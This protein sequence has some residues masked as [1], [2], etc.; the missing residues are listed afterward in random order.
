M[1]GEQELLRAMEE[2]AKE[3]GAIIKGAKEEHVAATEKTNFRDLVTSYDVK[4]QKYAVVFLGG[5]LIFGLQRSCQCMFLS[6]N[7]PKIS[8]FIALLRKVFLLVPLALILPKIF[9]VTGIYLA[10]SV[11]DATAATCCFLIFLR[12]FPKILDGVRKNT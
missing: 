1:Y 2:I 5:F 7:Q 9:G 8:L 11:A 4:V 12:R 3:C 6:M 10:E